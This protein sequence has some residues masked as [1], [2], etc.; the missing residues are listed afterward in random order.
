MVC[1]FVSFE[2]IWFTLAYLGF[3][4]SMQTK[5]HLFTYASFFGPPCSNTKLPHSNKI[6]L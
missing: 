6:T 1:L 4:L 2:H 3:L 5:A